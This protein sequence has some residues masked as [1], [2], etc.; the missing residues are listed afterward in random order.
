MPCSATRHHPAFRR[1]TII[2]VVKGYL[3]EF[4]EA[5]AMLS[6]ALE[7]EQDLKGFES[8]AIEKYALELAMFY[9][10]NGMF[11]KSAPY[12]ERGISVAIK[13]GARENDPI[14]L[15]QRYDEYA[16]T[17]TKLG[18]QSEADTARKEAHDLRLANP[19]QKAIYVPVRYHQNCTE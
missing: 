14:A 19:D 2:W 12:Y 7:L 4:D 1:L 5:E 3:C 9:H 8:E 17:L 11:E 6:K 10:D 15:A 13:F 16:E 18:R